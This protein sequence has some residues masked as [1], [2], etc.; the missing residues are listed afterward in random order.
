MALRAGAS[1]V[2]ASSVVLIAAL[3]APPSAHAV[4][5]GAAAAAA[6]LK[7]SAPLTT[8]A[9]PPRAVTGTVEL[10]K[11]GLPVPRF[12]SLKSGKV[13]VRNGPGEGYAIAWTFTRASLP[14]EVI[15]EFDTWRRVRDSDGSVGWVLQNLLSSKRTAVVAP[16][17]AGEPKPLHTSPSETGTVAAYVEAGIQAD[18]ASCHANW[19]KLTGRGFSGWIEQTSLWGVYPGEEIP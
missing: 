6:L 3:A 16:W 19:C 9:I 14:V 5:S 10:G 12:V 17:A 2:S 15:A 4:D 18:V 13:N 7:Q 8:G 11:S 1:L